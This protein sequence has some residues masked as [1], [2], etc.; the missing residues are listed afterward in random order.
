MCHIKM[1]QGGNALM[2]DKESTEAH[3]CIGQ[4]SSVAEELGNIGGKKRV[5]AEGSLDESGAFAKT[6]GSVHDGRKDACIEVASTSSVCRQEICSGEEGGLQKTKKCRLMRRRVCFSQHS[7]VRL[8]SRELLLSQYH[9]RE[10]G[11]DAEMDRPI[12]DGYGEESCEAEIDASSPSSNDSFTAE[13]QTMRGAAQHDETKAGLGLEIEGPGLDTRAQDQEDG[14][15]SESDVAQDEEEDEE[16][17]DEGDDFS[18]ETKMN[19]GPSLI[20]VLTQSLIIG[21]VEREVR[22]VADVLYTLRKCV[23]PH[24]FPGAKELEQHVEEDEAADSEGRSSSS[25]SSSSDESVEESTET[26]EALK[27][28]RRRRR[29]Q[30]PLT[31]EMILDSVVF[32]HVRE[33]LTKILDRI[34][35]QG[36][37][38]LLPSTAQIGTPFVPALEFLL[39]STKGAELRN[40]ADRRKLQLYSD[41]EEEYSD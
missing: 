16:E 8:C 41:S 37:A 19:D 39:Q 40:E 2:H 23:S 34:N 36:C 13:D 1:Q 14:N 6:N 10:C 30:V 38:S 35:S 5:R 25:A 21:L 33:H 17:E 32:E 18:V 12:Q 24:C 11:E 29:V 9:L 15:D 20:N 31:E 3:L 28:S 7:M 22:N 4:V 27:K 26:R